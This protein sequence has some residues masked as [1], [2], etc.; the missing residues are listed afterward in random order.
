MFPELWNSSKK[1]EQR[2]TIP[3]KS[4]LVIK[5][6]KPGGTS[7][8]VGGRGRAEG[9]SFPLPPPSTPKLE[10]LLAGT[11]GRARKP[12]TF[13]TK[14]SADCRFLANLLIT[15]YQWLAGD[16]AFLLCLNLLFSALLH[17]PRPSWNLRSCCPRPHWHLLQKKDQKPLWANK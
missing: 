11:G 16:P 8:R 3:T 1:C 14:W 4:L 10:S 13:H 17:F 15:S 12:L 6:S 5:S 2:A 7:C 9:A